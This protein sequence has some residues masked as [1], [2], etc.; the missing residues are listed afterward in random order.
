MTE[1]IYLAPDEHMPDFGDDQR[2]LIIEASS[3]GQFFG[4]GASWKSDGDW[5]G[6]GSL[7]EDDVSLERALAAAEAWATR[8]A[9]PIIWVQATP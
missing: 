4:S 7:I 5:V 8:Y 6:Y 2:W 1:I 9:V 3:D